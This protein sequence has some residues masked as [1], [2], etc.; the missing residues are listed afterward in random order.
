MDLPG[1]KILGLL[2]IITFF[3]SLVTSLLPTYPNIEYV[4]LAFTTEDNINHL[5]KLRNKTIE[6]DANFLKISIWM[7]ILGT[8]FLAGTIIMI[9]I[10]S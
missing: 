10:N 8:G 2:S 9:I 6:R 5:R 1:V 7:F 3:V 4:S